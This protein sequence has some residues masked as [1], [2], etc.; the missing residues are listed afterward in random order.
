T[1]PPTEPDDDRHLD[2]FLL[3]DR[4]VVE[5]GARLV[6][7][8]QS[9]RVKGLS[10]RITSL[11]KE[12]S[13]ANGLWVPPIR[14]NSNL[15]LQAEEYRI[16]IAG[17]KVAGAELRTEHM[18]A[19]LPDSKQ[20]S[21]TGETTTE[22]AFGL[23][24]RWITPESRRLAELQGCTVVDPLSVLITHLGEILKHH[25][26]ELLTREALKQML[27]RA[28][29]FAPT[30]VEEIRP[31]IIRMGTLH[32]VLVQLAE[33][34]IPLSDI[35]LILESIVN[36]APQCKAAE[37]LTDHVRAD[38]G[39][40]VCERFRGKDGRL[41]VIAMEPRLDS[42]MRQSIHN[43]QLALGA[44]PLTR[45]IENVGKAWKDS[46]RRQQPLAILVDQSMRRPIRKLLARTAPELGVIA[47]QEVPGDVVI[48]SVTM[49]QHD[50]ILG[51]EQVVDSGSRPGT[52]DGA[53]TRREAA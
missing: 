19:I 15:L 9:R 28:K 20:V 22:P 4:C 18:L 23:E 39:R 16:L 45:L 40:L 49:L 13:R 7:F 26:H 46:E 24:A 52:Y 14:V 10:E 27:D 50:E 38:L 34:R 53:T 35:A 44:V 33:D 48:D 30:I 36:H 31:E 25:G 21:I 32:Q 12:F 2:D 41:R 11:R 3:A 51:P 47:Y 29:E 17:R 37:E 43:D 6:P 42:R 8:I 5:V 1:P